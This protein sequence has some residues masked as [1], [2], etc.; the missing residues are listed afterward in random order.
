MAIARK[1]EH[2]EL[3]HHPSKFYIDRAYSHLNNKKADKFNALLNTLHVVAGETNKSDAWAIKKNSVVHHAIIA[4]FK[5]AKATFPKKETYNEIQ[6]KQACFMEHMGET[7][8]A[9]RKYD[10]LAKHAS[11][12]L[13][14]AA[15]NSRTWLLS[16][17]GRH[18]DALT[19][20]NEFFDLA[21][22]VSADQKPSASRLKAATKLKIGAERLIAGQ[23]EAAKDSILVGVEREQARVS[24]ATAHA[25]HFGRPVASKAAPVVHKKEEG[26]ISPLVQQL[27]Q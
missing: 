13:C 11:A 21:S 5:A 15:M 10:V 22:K 12:P 3:A 7:G 8:R 27:F 19:S 23:Q 2:E 4:L 26:R 25:T 1:G 24:V 20:V 18:E 17:K 14:W 9:L 6:M 16:S